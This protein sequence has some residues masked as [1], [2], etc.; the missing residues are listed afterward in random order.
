MSE[1]DKELA[2]YL[3]EL[4][5]TNPEKVPAAMAEII[6]Y[7]ALLMMANFFK[8]ACEDYIGTL[9]KQM[10][11]LWDRLKGSGGGMTA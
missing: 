8:S 10:N 4:A 11:E 5:V 7:Q 9:E 6:Q 3:A 1:L 2:K